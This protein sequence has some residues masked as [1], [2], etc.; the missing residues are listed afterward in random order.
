MPLCWA[1]P[2]PGRWPTPLTTP[3]RTSAGRPHTVS[4]T[5]GGRRAVSLLLVQ[6]GSASG[7]DVREGSRPPDAPT[8]GK[9]S[10]LDAGVRRAVWVCCSA[11]VQ[12]VGVVLGELH[13]RRHI[14]HAERLE[15][16][17]ELLGAPPVHMSL[18]LPHGESLTGVL[19]HRRPGYS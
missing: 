15:R 11:D 6:G 16:G 13:V 7:A 14:G 3:A 1:W 9:S 4:E 10:L 17:E 8:A 18:G 12:F 2:Q 19:I 5:P